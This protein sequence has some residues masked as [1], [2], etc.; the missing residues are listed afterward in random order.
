MT[1]APNAVTKL[2]LV[3]DDPSMVRLLTAVLQR[4]FHE[5]IEVNCLTNPEDAMA[6]IE[7]EVVE[8][9]ITDL[10]MPGISGLEL[11]QCAKRRNAFTQVFF[12]TGHSTLDALMGAF[13][14]GATDY[15]LKPL[16]QP[17]LI[18][19]VDDAQKRL[20]RWREALAGTLA[21]QHVPARFPAET[22]GATKSL[23]V[24]ITPTASA[25]P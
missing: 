9:L 18:E 13:E 14:M 2:L 19:L 8:I 17:Q 5:A 6:W 23:S 25:G 1:L 12:I 10:E 4:S 21:A 15:L 11:L 7:R 3:D 24:P 22:T 16:D 20:R